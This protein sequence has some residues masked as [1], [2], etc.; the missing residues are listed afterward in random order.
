MLAPFEGRKN[1]ATIN[2]MRAI[3]GG[4][5]FPKRHRNRIVRAQSFHAGD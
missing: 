2:G 3:D 4:A 5:E 1:A